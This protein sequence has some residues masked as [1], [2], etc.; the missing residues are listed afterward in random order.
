[1]EPAVEKG[2]AGEGGEEEADGMNVIKTHYVSMK[3]HNDME[4][5]I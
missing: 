2:S 3:S 5:Y 4:Y 1:M